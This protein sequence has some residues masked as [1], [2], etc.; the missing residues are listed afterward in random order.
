M[1]YPISTNEH[2]LT[3]TNELSTDWTASPFFYNSI[4]EEYHRRGYKKV[5]TNPRGEEFAHDEWEM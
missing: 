2:Q 1:E 3:N 5:P 4:R